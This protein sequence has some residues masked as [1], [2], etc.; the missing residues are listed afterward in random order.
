[1]K[2]LMTSSGGILRGIENW[3]EY[4]LARE[5]VRL[6]HDVTV[7]SSSSVLRK[8]AAMKEETIEGIRVKRFNPVLPSSFFYMLGT[9]FDVV[10]MHHLGYL[11]PI[12]SYAAFRKKVKDVP[13]VFTIHGIYHDPYIV[14][15]IEDPL[16]G[17]IKESVQT[18]FPYIKLW[19]IF[20]WFV[21][22]PLNADKITALTAWEKQETMKLGIRGDRI[23][24]VPNGV[25]LGKYSRGKKGDYFRRAGIDGE[26]L[27]FVGQP[28]ERKGWKYFLGAMPAILKRFPD[29]KA[30]F[31]G[32]RRDNEL[33]ETCR[34]LG[35]EDSVA[36]PGFLPEER[37]IEA[38]R[39]SDVFV[40]PTLYEGFGIV[41]LESMAAG[42]PII[43][44]DVAGNSEIVRQGKNGLL[45][46]PRN[47]KEIAGAA[48]RLLASKPLRE[49]IRRNNLE[50]AGKYDWKKVAKKYLDVYESVVQ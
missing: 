48:V 42:V 44:T 38:F 13:A 18:G 24:V 8:H 11:A 5:L 26:I 9:S 10:H 37:K 3:P 34:R 31:V 23:E 46:R 30:V 17:E 20:N 14:G 40:L 35:I 39:S 7:L 32:Y 12:S 29:A 27:L 45:V 50:D 25:D 33:E 49:R 4:G 41:F 6:G 21:H 16:S 19:K 28:A 15:N 1:M 2:I 47:S 43:T 22:L 36:F